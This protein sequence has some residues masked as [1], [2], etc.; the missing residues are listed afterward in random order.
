MS[1]LATRFAAVTSL[2][3]GLLSVVPAEALVLHPAD[4]PPTLLSK[5]DDAVVG[6][7]LGVNEASLVVVAPNHAITTKHQGGGIGTHVLIGTTTYKVAGIVNH[8]TADLRVIELETLADT[9]ANLTD[10]VQVYDQTDEV[11]QTAVLGGYGEVRGSAIA[12]GYNWAGD[13]SRTLTWGANIIDSSGTAGANQ[14]LIADFD[15]DANGVYGETT[16]AEGDSGGGWFIWTGSDW[17]V[18]ALNR[19]VAN[20]NQAIYSPTPEYLDGVRLSSYTTFINSNIPEPTSAALLLS[21]IAGLS[22]RRRRG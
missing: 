17:K 1:H 3:A 4:D 12:G 18:A 8:P 10:F 14:V 19:A 2:C 20:P 15:S 13:A 5:P 6:Q 7:W 22:L 9:P 11:G 16:I 21:A